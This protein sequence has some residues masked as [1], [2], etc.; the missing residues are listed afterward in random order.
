MAAL[1]L[2]MLG[3][4]TVAS[5]GVPLELPASRKVRALLAYL[6]LSARAVSRQRLC[7]VLWDTTADPRAELRWHLSKL[8][9]IVGAERIRQDEDCVR[10]DLTDCHVDAREVQRFMQAGI[11]DLPP[12]RVRELHEFFRGEFL[13]GLELDHCPQFMGWL[14][15]QRRRFRDWRVALLEQLAQGVAGDEALGHIETWLQI[16]PFDLR[17][18]QHLFDVLARRA[19]FRD[20]DEHLVV[21]TRL[22]SAEGL[23]CAA[24]KKAWRASTARR[25]TIPASAADRAGEQAYDCYLLGRQHLARMMQ[26]GLEQGRQMFDRAV[27]LEPG[28]GPAW[29]GLATVHACRHEW[30]DAGKESFALADQASRRALETAPQL[31]EAHVARGLV[32]SQ[33]QHYD[34]AVRE[35]EEAIRINPYLFDAYYFFARAAVARGDMVRAADMFALAMQARPADFQSPILLALPMKALGR[36]DEAREAVRT[37]IQRAEL[38]LAINPCDG[39]ALSLGAAALADDGQEDRAQEWSKRALELFPDDSSAWVNVAC[40]HAKTGESG[41]A[42]DA[43]EHVFARGHGKRDWVMND[44]DYVSLLREPRFQQMLGRLK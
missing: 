37:G 19:R 1:Q 27:G 40:M 33:S 2:K 11:A 14:L 39:R 10:L 6:A 23:D 13:E 42:L 29:A 30:F 17:A 28:Y 41:K 38:V 26:R 22:F 43:L 34:D 20:G 16:A 32:R 44:P 7:E 31:A 15:A 24:L 9:A 35:F 4:L 36:E 12:Q 8:R 21:S 18:H 25:A 5:D 3:L